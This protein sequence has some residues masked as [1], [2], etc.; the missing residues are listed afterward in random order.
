M[1]AKESSQ[2]ESAQMRFKVKEN[3]KSPGEDGLSAEFYKV[4]IYQCN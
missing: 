3:N 4:F 1:L 2:K